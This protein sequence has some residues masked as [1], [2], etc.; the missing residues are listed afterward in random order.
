MTKSFSAPA[1]LSAPTALS[2]RTGNLWNWI[3]AFLYL[4]NAILV[5]SLP[6]FPSQDG[7]VHLYYTEVIRD[8]LLNSGQYGQYFAIKQLITPYAFQYYTM[9]ALETVFTPEMSEKVLICLYLA[10]FGLGFKYL[11]ES[12][13]RRNTPW[14]LTSLPFAMH[15]L[16]FMGF[17]NF[18]FAVALAMFLCGFWLRWVN[19]LNT[20]A[21]VIIVLT[22]LFLMVVHPVPLAIFLSFAG[23][24]LLVDLIAERS[25]S[26]QTL[27]EAIMARRT[28]IILLFIFGIVGLLWVIMFRTEP[29]PNAMRNFPKAPQD[30]GWV[31]KMTEEVKLWPIVPYFTIP[32]RAGP[33]LLIF[34]AIVAIAAAVPAAL[35]KLPRAAVVCLLTSAACYLLYV[36]AP[37]PLNGATYFANRFPIFWVVFLFASAAALPTA[38]PSAHS[39]FR[40]AVPVLA[41]PVALLSLFLQWRHTSATAAELTPTLNAKV[42]GPGSLGLICSDSARDPIRSYDPHLWLGVH[43]FRRSKAV[44]VNA[45]WMYLPHI[46]LKPVKASD[47]DFIDPHPMADYLGAGDVKQLPSSNLAFMIRAGRNT[48]KIAEATG[49]WGYKPAGYDN[50]IFEVYAKPELLPGIAQNPTTASGLRQ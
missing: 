3:A 18:C 5:L 48:P 28:Q 27:L 24:T 6:I 23:L 37:V 35:R 20:R 30:F 36:F 13:G 34:A 9:I 26:S 14:V 39:R 42:I 19:R 8:L 38:L 32:Y 29:S 25:N 21:L 1:T 43:Y 2:D 33:V 12:V 40:Y 15:S 44:L 11:L 10:A 49:R 31:H 47:W 22:F 45:P 7:P 17:L 4:I 50:G 46:M 41:I 16:V